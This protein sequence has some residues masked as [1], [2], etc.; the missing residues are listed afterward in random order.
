MAKRKKIKVKRKAR[1]TM[2]AAEG[3]CKLIDI[4]ERRTDKL[5]AAHRA[6]L[7]AFGEFATRIESIEFVLRDQLAMMVDTPESV[8]K[9][10]QQ[11]RDVMTNARGFIG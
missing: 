9:K 5:E 4:L 6:T 10:A 7:R 11:A 8:A 3:I 2:T 1:V